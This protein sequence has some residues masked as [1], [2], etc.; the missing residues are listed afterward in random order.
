MFDQRGQGVLCGCGGG[1]PGVK[2]CR[3]VVIIKTA[4]QL[5]GTGRMAYGRTCILVTAAAEGL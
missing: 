4:W 5:D 1:A 3:N 2:V